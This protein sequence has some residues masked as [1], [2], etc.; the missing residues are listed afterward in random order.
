MNFPPF[1]AW[2]AGLYAALVTLS[3]TIG[4][5]YAQLA[6]TQTSIGT[7]AW[8]VAGLGALVAAG[9]AVKAAWPVVIPAVRSS[10]RMGSPPEQ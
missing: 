4:A 6:D 5:Q 8:V 2:M 3:T 1:R 10:S 9:G 7:G